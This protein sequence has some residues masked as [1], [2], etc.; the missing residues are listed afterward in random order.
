MAETHV[1]RRSVWG[2]FLLIWALALLLLGAA[3]CF[4][5]YRYLGVYEV[6]RPEPVLDAFLEE[7]DTEAIL[8]QAKNNVILELTEFEDGTRLY[9]SYLD[10]VDTTRPLNYRSD[11]KNSDGTQ[12]SYLISSGPNA[13]C[14]VLLTPAGESPGFGRHSWEVS[15]VRAAQITDLLPSLQL[16]VDATSGTQLKLN[17]KPLTDDYLAEK[18]IRIPDLTRL[19][20][21][22][23]PV[24]TF[25]RY[26][27]GP[28]YG[29]VNLTDARGNTL[30]PDSDSDSGTLHYQ[31]SLG[32]G[33][34]SIRAPED[35]TVYVN[36]VA[37]D[38]LDITTSDLGVLSGLDM[39]T[40][41]AACKTN[42]YL[43]DGLYAVPTVTAFDKDGNEIAPVVSGE[44]N[45]SF[46]YRNDPEIEELLRPIAERFFSA[47]MDYSG[48]RWEASRYYNLL[49]RILYGTE[50]YN[51]VYN[52]TDAMYWASGTE[53]EYKDLRFEN[54]HKVSDFCYTCTVIYSADM[55][56]TSWYEQ[57]SYSLENA[58]ELAFI[59][60]G[61]NW[62]AAGM[63][64]ITDA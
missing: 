55:T 17:G 12:L 2:R 24:P 8:Q 21:E 41:G 31:A 49:N 6:T 33:R 25:V 27:V 39:Y 5:L 32:S 23:D 28:L 15:E 43:F 14:T 3:G 47:Y 61:G 35:L 63:N 20:A 48:H 52:S 40:Q 54:F 16:A 64:V 42:T 4:V 9:E 58:Y 30:N 44:N 1:R 50:L 19:E 57:Y 7:N 11:S 10:A 59:T 51:Y 46:F 56:A 26:E 38:T 29:E 53:T 34:L 36:G 22:M 62:Y 13:L 37:L 45:F 60:T 18:D